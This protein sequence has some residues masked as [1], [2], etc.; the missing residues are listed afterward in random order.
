MS[1]RSQAR[2]EL[3]HLDK[4]VLPGTCIFVWLLLTAECFMVQT[5]RADALRAY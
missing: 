1:N 4:P 2:C 5:R 3:G